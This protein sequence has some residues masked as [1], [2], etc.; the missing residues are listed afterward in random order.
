MTELTIKMTVYNKLKLA[1]LA[2]VASQNIYAINVDPVQIQSAP[3][4]LLYAEMTFRQSDINLPIEVS[5]ASPEDLLSIGASHQPPG[6]LNFFTRRSNNGT[7]VITITSSRPMTER[8]LN[9]IVKI[10]EGNAARLQHI[11]TPLQAKT[12]LLKA[13]LKQNERPLAPVVVVSEKDIALNLPV[14]S[15]Y[16]T[17]ASAA[18]NKPP[19]LE[20]PLALQRTAP[21]VLSNISIPK[22]AFAPAVMTSSPAIQ[23]QAIAPVLKSE[24]VTA[25]DIQAPVKT[26]AALSDS[27]K[28]SQAT[29]ASPAPAAAST[30]NKPTSTIPANQSASAPNKANMQKAVES[31]SDHQTASSDPLV[32][33]F[34]EEQARKSTGSAN[35]VKTPAPVTTKASPVKATPNQTQPT[36]VVRSNESLWGIA[37]RIAQQ[38]QRPVNEVMQQIKK[39]NEHAF[40][41]GNAN[42]LRKGAALN[43][44]T[45]HPTPAPIKVTAAKQ[46]ELPSKPT[47]K[48]KYRLNQAE[49]SL[50]AENQRDSGQVSANQNTERN[51]TSKE[52]SL[53]VM[54]AREK[55]VKL[56]RNVTELELALNQKDHRIQLLNARLA[57]LQQQL[58]AQ[59]ADKKPIN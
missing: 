11:R 32:K 56:Q 4:E 26:A 17:A 35:P 53:K 55:T 57:Q 34:A 33:K 40:I 9:I 7:G 30:T 21:P 51:Q 48:T 29:L 22:T 45:T 41:G 14:S 52:L 58:K 15:H 42:R 10:K 12:D 59:Q 1:I 47:G 5:L 37:S 20:K 36:Y 49:M 44:N 46:T 27:V 6:H 24:A 13:S 31:H 50:V 23:A 54:T 39:D 16:S 25:P 38:Q 8:E 28:T 43:L 3:G 18:S 19:V 2:I